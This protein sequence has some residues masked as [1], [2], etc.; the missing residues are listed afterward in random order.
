MVGG[1]N[2][3]RTRRET[4]LLLSACAQAQDPRFR[5]GIALVRVDA[6]VIHNGRIVEGLTP[7]DFLLLDNGAPQPLLRGAQHLEAVDI[8]LLFDI[9]G[10]MEWVAEQV[11]IAAERALGALSEGDRAGVMVFHT[12]ARVVQ[13]LTSELSNVVTAVRKHVLHAKMGGETYLLA[14]ADEAAK[15]FRDSTRGRRRAVIVVTDNYGSPSKREVSVVRR[16][17]ESDVICSAILTPQDEQR[18][19]IWQSRLSRSPLPP[20]EQ[21]IEGLVLKTGGTLLTTAQPG[22]ALREMMQRLRSRYTLYYRMP[23]GKQGEMRRVE[24]RLT[25]D[26]ADRLPDAIIRARGGYVV[27]RRVE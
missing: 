19:Q 27:P 1:P 5:T 17:W 16:Y 15:S 22:E 23:G 7:D 25:K 6:E 26:A 21:G 24:V 10:S 12:W 13:P 9:S 8:M 2:T 4:L 20:P 14:A 3:L 11:S 18:R